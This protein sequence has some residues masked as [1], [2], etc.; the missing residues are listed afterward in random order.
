MQGR[1]K[2]SSLIEVIANSIKRRKT[3]CARLPNP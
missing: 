2:Y 3:A 1:P